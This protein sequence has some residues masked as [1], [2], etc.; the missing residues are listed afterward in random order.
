M[1]RSSVVLRLSKPSTCVY[2]AY[3]PRDRCFKVACIVEDCHYT[4]HPHCRSL[5][6]LDCH[7]EQQRD[8]TEDEHVGLAEITDPSL[9]P[10]LQEA[11]SEEMAGTSFNVSREQLQQLIEEYNSGNTS[12]LDM[13]L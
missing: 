12:G 7:G 1:F 2:L 10:L 6:T 9:E 4:C 13:V 11:S 3:C 5:V 8:T